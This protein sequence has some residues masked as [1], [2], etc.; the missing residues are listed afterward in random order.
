MSDVQLIVALSLLGG[1]LSLDSTAFLQVMLSQPLAAG[2]LAG[3][4][5]GDLATGLV[6]GAALQLVWIGVIPVG[7]APF[8]DG[9]VAGVAGV[10]A[11][12][13][14]AGHGVSGG[15][16]VASGIVVGICAGAAGQKV[17][18]RVR[19]A[20]VRFSDAAERR[21]EVGDPSGVR[22]AVLLGLGT[23]FVSAAALTGAAL[24]CS[25][26]LRSL[27]PLDVRGAFPTLVW[28]APIAAAALVV[29]GKGWEKGFIAAGFVAGLAAVI[30]T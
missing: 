21:A 15:L 29:G 6:V 10:G 12:A 22:T 13:L 25:M 20:N 26:I 24:S 28:A 16:A 9:A 8:P 11:A 4:A 30:L 23:R 18:A 2:A 3:L 27:V 17:T 7:A 1:L 14:L 5:T 19:R